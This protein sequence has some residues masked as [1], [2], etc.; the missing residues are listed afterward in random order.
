VSPVGWL[1]FAGL[2][3]IVG[4]SFRSQNFR[5]ALIGRSN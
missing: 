3:I 4:L 2:V 1:G 5:Q